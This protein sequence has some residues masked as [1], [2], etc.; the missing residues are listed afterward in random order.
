MTT[1]D[2]VHSAVDQLFDHIESEGRCAI[3]AGV[4]VAHLGHVESGITVESATSVVYDSRNLTALFGAI[5]ALK[6]RASK[7]WIV[8]NDQ[9]D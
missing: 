1:R 9:D 7:L 2:E 6:N 8:R 4:A 5:E 3:G